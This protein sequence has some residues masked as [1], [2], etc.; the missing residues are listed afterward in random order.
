MKRER[1]VSI[2][3]RVVRDVIALLTLIVD[4][5]EDDQI[6]PSR[7]LELSEDAANLR[8]DLRDAIAEESQQ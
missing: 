2:D 1:P 5:G 7:V 3:R 4:A 8:D 6:G